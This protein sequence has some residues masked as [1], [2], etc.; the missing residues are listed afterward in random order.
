MPARSKAQVRFLHHKFGHAWVKR[1]HF[2]AKG[3]AYKKLPA[4]KRR[5]R[6]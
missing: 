6:R 4:R 1:H 2:N 3:K 5:K